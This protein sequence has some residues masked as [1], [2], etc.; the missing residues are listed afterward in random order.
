M[1][2]DTE[3]YLR[4]FCESNKSENIRR[5]PLTFR[6]KINNSSQSCTHFGKDEGNTS[7][8]SGTRSDPRVLTVGLQ[9]TES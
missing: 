6:V 2:F 8:A 5:W 7:S 1:Q 4:R 3:M 9:M